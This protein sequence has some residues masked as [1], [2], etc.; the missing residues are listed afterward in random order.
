M[1]LSTGQLAVSLL[2]FN[3][4]IEMVQ[5]LL[6][7]L[8]LPC[9]VVV[10]RT[11]FGPVFRFA[12]AAVTGVAATGWLADRLGLANPVARAADSAG[13]DPKIMLILLTV[14]AVTALGWTV[15]DRANRAAGRTTRPSMT[16]ELPNRG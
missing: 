5:L 1:D 2:G 15:L 13:A 16:S 8:A 3:L 12:V 14:A 10:A 9:L 11:R 7:A 4:G 6:V